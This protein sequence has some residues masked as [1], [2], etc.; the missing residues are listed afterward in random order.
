MPFRTAGRDFVKGHIPLVFHLDRLDKMVRRRKPTLYFVNSLSDLFHEDASDDQIAQVF[1]A[2]ATTP[3]NTFQVLTKRPERMVEL[4]RRTEFIE[5]TEGHYMDRVGGFLP[6]PWPLPHVWMGVSIENRR[7][8]GRADLLRE[9]PAAV[10][11]ISAEPLLGP[12]VP[13]RWTDDI[14]VWDTLKGPPL[15]LTGID[16]LIA[17]GESGPNA[18]RLDLQWMRDLRD[19]CAREGVVYFVKQLGGLRPGT[20]LQD[21]PEDLQIREYPRTKETV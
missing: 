8:V 4:L 20:A 14:G 15:N 6:M 13:Q 5:M 21:L 16:W 19:A 17:G 11:F 9:T 2:M 18:R 3:H 10:R 12:L 7:F 1:G